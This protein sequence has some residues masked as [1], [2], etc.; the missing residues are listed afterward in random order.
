MKKRLVTLLLSLL[1]ALCVVCVTACN[2]T[3]PTTPQ[4]LS[5]PVVVL[6]GNL[7]TWQADENADKFEISLGGNLSYVE[8]TVT[9]KVLLNGQTF[10]IRAI[11]DGINY[12]NSPWSNSV[13]YSE[14]GVNPQPTALSV[15]TVTISSTGLASWQTVANAIGYAYKING[16]NETQTQSTSVQLIDGQSITVKALGDGATYTDSAY[17]QTK[18]YSASTPTPTS[19]PTY[20]G[21]TASNSEPTVN[22]KPTTLLLSYGSFISGVSL[23]DSIKTYF[24][25]ANNSLGDQAPTESDYEIYSSVGNTV[26]IQIWLNNP[27]QNTILSLK[28]NGVKY[29]SGGALQSF[30]IQDGNSYLNC[31]YV[32]VTIPNNSYSEISYQVTEIEY[33]EGTNVSQDG[34]AVL[35]DQDKD[36][37]S[38]GLPFEQT[39]PTVTL[40]N[41]TAT[42]NTISFDA[43]VTDQSDYVSLVNGWLRVIIYDSDYQIIAQQKLTAGENA[44]TFNGLSADT[45]YSVM[46]LIFADTHDGN[47]VYPHTI[48]SQYYKTESVIAC[49]FESQLLLNEQTEKYYPQISVTAE[50]SDASFNFT[51]IEVLDSY[52]DNQLVYTSNFDGSIDITDNLLNGHSYIVKVYYE[53]ANSVEQSYYEYVYVDDLYYPWVTG[54]D[55]AYGLIDDAVLG[56]DFG[57]EKFNM[58][59]LTIRIFD[60][61]SKQYLA[62]NALYLIENPNAIED[63]ESQ[64]RSMGRDNPDFNSIYDR[65]YKLTQ[66]KERIEQYHPEVTKQEWQT[67]LAKGVYIYEFVY[68]QDGEFFKGVGNKYYVLLEDYQTYR[69][70]DYSWQYVI[71]ADFDRNNG[72]EVEVGREITKGHFSIN[73]ALTKND[74]LFVASDEHYNELFTVDENNVLY[75][76]LMSRNN[77]GNESYRNLGYVNQIVLADGYEILDVLWTQDAPNIDIDESAWFNEV[78]N[79]LISGNDVNS[80]FPLGD[81]TPITFD[82]D[83]IEIAPTLIGDY[84]IRFTYK[85]YGKE[86]TGENPYDW[87]GSTVDYQVSGALPTAS[88]EF[89]SGEGEFGKYDIVLPDSLSSDRY[90]IKFTI[91]IRDDNQQPIGTYNQDNYTEYETLSINYSI[92]IRLDSF[93]GRDY[94]TQGEFS[95]WF[96]CTPITLS[97]PTNFSQEY[98]SYGV[99][100]T[101]DYIDGAEKYLYVLNDGAEKETGN[102]L[103]MLKNGDTI[104]V[105]A[106]PTNATTHLESAWSEVYTVTDTRT[107][108]AKPVLTFDTDYLLLTWDYVENADYYNIYNAETGELLYEYFYDTSYSVQMGYKYIVMAVPSDYESYCAS[109]SE[110]IDTTVKLQTPIVSIDESGNVTFNVEGKVMGRITY[111]YVINDGEEQST[112][113]KSGVI[114]LNDGDT[115]KVKISCGNYEDSNWTEKTY[116]K[117]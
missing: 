48:T 35:I 91:E 58:D 57:N 61:Y 111:V 104:K 50:L 69:T 44:V 26:Y 59:N 39:Q 20:L 27:D 65:W 18:T 73:P 19:A 99:S 46:A 29:Q 41:Q 63:L 107:T 83:D 5:A 64:W 32:A 87:S 116:Q 12:T 34:K 60:E 110:V 94:Y 97:T 21:I 22:D 68:G 23:E 66:A 88:I 16:G 56:F 40:S 100:V 2:G 14:S 84:S 11:G 77:L 93:N 75:L 51:K 47:G 89:K 10:K 28:L 38:I 86:Y 115:I 42:A 85:M 90:N 106:V 7:A 4:K 3:P 37:V 17:S 62:E 96:T 31:V 92:R 52:N 9:S 6:N 112:T 24:Q 70:N 114:T 103:T 1:T 98:T 54:V 76:E 49:N 113:K 25:D 8:N 80:I 43:S 15:P 82:L 30:F 78:K 117:A 81:L 36:T 72:E 105:K 71:T 95:E 109:Q 101:W 45:Y 53:N 33:V 67:E 55:L 108:L 74:Y 102:Q 13:T 79:A